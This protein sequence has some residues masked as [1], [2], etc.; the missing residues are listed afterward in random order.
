MLLSPMNFMSAHLA[1]SKHSYK[2]V[3]HSFAIKTCILELLLTYFPLCFPH[4]Y[5]PEGPP[6]M[7]LG[8]KD[9]DYLHFK[10]VLPGDDSACH[11]IRV[12]FKEEKY[13]VRRN[14]PTE[15]Y[16]HHIIHLYPPLVFQNLLPF[17][18]FIDSMVRIF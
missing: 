4:S 5:E 16:A 6:I 14:I 18:I 1:L 13:K 11:Y 10:S 12:D 7:W 9:S 3:H 17:E 8:R 15:D 2:L